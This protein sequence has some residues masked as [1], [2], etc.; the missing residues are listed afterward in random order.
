MKGVRVSIHTHTHTLS[1]KK[2]CDVY[3]SGKETAVTGVSGL[4]QLF[5]VLL[6]VPACS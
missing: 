4:T 5:Y 1:G 6:T 3:L 2:D